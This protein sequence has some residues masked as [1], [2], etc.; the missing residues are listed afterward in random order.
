MDRI[1]PDV[2]VAE[3]QPEKLMWFGLANLNSKGGKRVQ[4]STAILQ[5][6][7]VDATLILF[8]KQNFNMSMDCYGCRDVTVIAPGETLLGFPFKDF[9]ALTLSIEYLNLKAIPN[10]RKKNALAAIQRKVINDSPQDV[11]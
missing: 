10:S 1:E 8:L 4:S 7:C 6:A 5:A 3:D 9:K 11:H 2:V